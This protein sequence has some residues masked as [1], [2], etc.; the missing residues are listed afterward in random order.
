VLTATGGS[1]GLTAQTTFTDKVNTSLSV[2]PATGNYGGTVNLS[3]ILTNA[4][5]GNRLN[6]RTVSFSL[7]GTSVGSATTDLSGNASLTGVSLGSISVGTY[8][9]G[10]Q[11]SFAGDAGF[12]PSSGSAQLTV[13]PATA[14]TSLS[15]A[16]ASGTYGGTVGLS[17]TLTSGGS[18]VSGKTIDF[19]LNG[20]DVGD[21][22]TNGSGMATLNDVSLSGID[23]GFYEDYIGASFAGDSNYAASSG[24]GNLTVSKADA[25]IVVTPYDVTYDG[26]AHTATG[27]ATGVDDE[28]LSGLDLS[29]TTHTNA[30]FYEDDPWTFT[31]STGNYNDDSGT[32]DDNIDKA[33]AVIVV[34]P[35]DVTY[36]GD[37]HTATGTA[38]GVKGEDL[39]ADL[40]LSGTTHTA[41]GDYTG[42]AWSFTDS[43]GNY[44]DD[45]GTVDDNIDK[46]DA[47]IVVTP[48]DVTYDGDAHT[49]DGTAT[50]VKGED[51]SADL[52]L[53]GTTHTAAGD[54]TGDTWSFTDSTGNYNDDNGTVD[55]NIDKANADIDVT[56]YDVT[57]DG[58]AHTAT[59]TA[60]GVKG[61]DLSA[62]LDLSGTTHTAAGDYTGDAWSFT[63]STGNYNDDNGTVDD[64]ID[65]ADAVIVVTPYDVTYDCEA[66]TATGGATGVDDESLSGLDLSGTTHTAA[67]DY[68]GDAW[69]FTDVTGNYNNDSGT[70]DDNIDKA[71][72]TVT[73]DDKTKVYGEP[74]PELTAHAT[75]LAH[76]DTLESLS[77]GYTLGTSADAAS[78][79]GT[80]D[81]TI[82]GGDTSTTNYSPIDYEEGTLTVTQA[83]TTTD[84]KV[85][86]S[87]V[88]YKDLITLSA[89]VTPQNTA[90]LLTG[91]V[92]F[93]IGSMSYGSA[94][95]VPIPGDPNGAVLATV[96]TQVNNLPDDYTV[97]AAFTSTNTNYSDSEGTTSL[98]VDQREASVYPGNYNFYTG[99]NLVW[100]TG[101]NSSTGTVTLMATIFDPETPEG[102]VRAATVTF[103]L[104][105]QPIS[106][107]KNL[108]VNLVDVTDG[109]VGTA[110]AVVQLNIG[111]ADSQDYEITV[112]I[113]G[114]YFNDPSDGDSQAL[115]VVAKPITGGRLFSTGEISNTISNTSGSGSAGLIKGASGAENNTEF[116]FDVK[117]NSTKKGSNATNPQGKVTLWVYSYYDKN[118]MLTTAL[119][120]YV[121]KSNAISV[122][123]ITEATKATFSAKCTVQEE[124]PNGS[125]TSI[126]GGAI[127]QI[128]ATNG[129][130][131]QLGITVQKSKGG[132]WYSSNWQGGKTVEKAIFSGDILLAP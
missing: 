75:G 107:A 39:S 66:H 37:A 13:N 119:H 44:N 14:S 1:S 84:A 41:A 16:N 68:T 54:Y 12:N 95:V 71:A 48:Y 11:A 116:F 61:E 77:L 51:L 23:A 43:T 105:G 113:G 38:T 52:D 121:I 9:T 19:T 79:V 53:S 125:T 122:L 65:K 55:D 3:A 20:V 50:G 35:Y 89:I 102:D 96:I 91:S 8:P 88:R 27:S 130:P 46:A 22:T 120:N 126:D 28:S 85:S 87:T 92:A 69:S 21:S 31:D 45:N 123:A 58:D 90:S 128:T 29:G 81:I 17:A 110:S 18:G 5:N 15:V 117:Y 106:S 34:T 4:Q 7:N 24:T 64:N 97:T 2:S 30:G 25:D 40:D 104:N 118:G 80:Y 99:P 86:A 42:D 60:T 47:V 57:Y 70:V 10:V 63:D 94:T 101:P 124:L 103:K 132:L 49:A 33:D 72:L 74:L 114:A 115:L 73:A 56:A 127:M 32:V 111:S 100:T 98:H 36:D 59:A 67:G 78:P 6:G 108:P 83:T 93:T 131:D 129:N 62:D 26:D 82:E 109:T 76:C 112:V